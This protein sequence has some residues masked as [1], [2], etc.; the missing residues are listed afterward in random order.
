MS[1]ANKMAKAQYQGDPG[2][3]GDIWKGIK[4]VGRA[5]T[6]IVGGLGIPIVSGVARTAGGILFGGSPRNIIPG[7][8]TFPSMGGGMPIN[9]ATQFPSLPGTGQAVVPVPGVRGFFERAIPGGATG[10][11]VA[12]GPPAM[13]G[14]HWNKS[15]YF[16][17]SGEYVAPGS[18]LVKNRRRNPGNMK[19]LSRSM[20]RIK[21][22]KRMASVLGQISIR[23]ACPPSRRRSKH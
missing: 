15:G 16:L 20:G 14:Y 12:G 8:S 1:L 9:L 21:S 17:M 11:Q 13:T 3:F 19:A 7:A 2:L 10:L 4:G 23:S 18:K 22:A 5:A 6:G